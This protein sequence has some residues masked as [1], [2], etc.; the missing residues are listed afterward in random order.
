M[1]YTPVILVFG[2]LRQEDKLFLDSLGYIKT[3]LSQKP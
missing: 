1:A 2:R 3:T